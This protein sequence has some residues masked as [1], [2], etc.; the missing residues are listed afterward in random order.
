[1]NLARKGL[2]GC[3]LAT[4][5][6]LFLHS[7]PV[8]TK[9]TPQKENFIE[10]APLHLSPPEIWGVYVCECTIQLGLGVEPGCNWTKME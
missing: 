3:A 4:L 9:F 5:E 10:V 7:S 1:M 2:T 6:C 8:T